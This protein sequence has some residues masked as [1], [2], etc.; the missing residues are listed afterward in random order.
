[1]SKVDDGLSASR[2]RVAAVLRAAKDVVSID[3]V[4][5][6][7]AIEL[8]QAAKLLSRWAGQGWVRRI[9]RGLY[10]PVPLD[11]A[12]NT[13]IVE[14]PW[15]L[16]PALFD[17]SYIGG[18]TA[19]HHWDLTEQLFN[20]T[21]VFTTKRVDTPRVAAQGVVFLPHH[22]AARHLFGL[23][24]VWRGTTRVQFSDPA[25]TALARVRCLVTIAAHFQ[26]RILPRST[27]TEE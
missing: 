5:R 20:E 2:A 9:G 25:R 12:G 24:P 23:K 16:V 4:E 19:A 8:Q 1:M 11:L 17:Q 3:L 6:T 18:W 26:S 22:V 15:L 27:I 14:D 10:V 21:I 7:L 13:Q